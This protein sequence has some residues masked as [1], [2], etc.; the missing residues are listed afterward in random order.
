MKTNTLNVI[1]RKFYILFSLIFIFSAYN[2]SAQTGCE[3]SKDHGQCY[4]T[5]ISSVISNGN[6]SYTIVLIV[7]NSGCPGPGCKKMTHYSVEAD[8]GTYSNISVHT[9]T[10][11][12]TY[13][14]INFGPNIGC[15]FQG[16]RINGTN[17]MGNGQAS[18]FSVTYTLTGGLQDEQAMV[19]TNSSNLI[20]SFSLAD[21]QSVLNCAD[22]NIV[23]YYAAP[24]GGKV[25]DIIG[26]E[27]TS[28]HTTYVT[29]GTYASDDI[30]QIVG[31]SV[32]IDVH[33]KP[34][35]YDSAM[36]ILTSPAYGLA[37]PEGN[38][39][40]NRITGLFPIVNLLMLNSLHTLIKEV[41]PVYTALGNVGIVTSQGDTAMRSYLARNGF[42][43]S[44]QGIKVGV[45]SDSYNT[46]TGDPAH[47]DV[48]RGDLPGPG[49]PDN[50]SPVD[51]VKDYPY[52]SRS[53]EGRAMLQIVHDIAPGAQLAFR[54]GFL[55]VADFAK[56]I[57]ELKQAGCNVIVDDITYI[58][59][60][61]FR[62]GIVSQAV[63][64][65]TSE[66]VAYFSA[67]GNFG[68]RS[69]Q[70]T[71]YPVT[72]PPGITGQ[73][74][75]FAGGTG[76]TDIYQSISLTAGNYTVV[77]QWDDGTAGNQTNSD[78][79]IY[80][81]RPNGTTLFGFNHVNTGGA[82]IEVLPFTVTGDSAQTN[83][84]IIRSAGTGAATLKYVV[85]RG[86]IVI[87]EYANSGGSSTLVGQ[88]NASGAIAVGAVL[89]SNTPEYGVNPP[90][91]ASFSSRGGTPVNGV[92]RNKPDI[93]A[94]N[95]VNTNVNLGGANIDGDQFPN[96]FGT[97]AAAPHAAGVA[98]LL[99]EAKQKYYGTS[100]SPANTRTIL[101]ST[102]LDMYTP[103]YDPASGAGFIQA[104]AALLSLANPSPYITGISYDTTLVPG[105]DTI[106]LTVYGQYLSAQSQIY[107]NGAPL[108]GGTVLSGDT[109]LIGTVLPF[110]ERYPEIQAY[111]PPK[112]GTNGTDGG[113]SN[114]LYFTT[115]ETIV[116]SIDDKSK[117]YGEV[118]PGFTAVY[119]VE[120][121]NGSFPLDSA[122]LTQAETARIL[123]VS[124]ETVATALSNTGLWEIVANSND[125]LN[126]ASQV[127][128][129]D[130]LDISLLER[131][132][133]AFE[134]GLLNIDKLD[135]VIKPNDT[136]FTFGDAIGG[137]SFDYLFN[138]DSNNVVITPQD[139]IAILSALQ[140]S[141]ATAL[142]N[143][144]ALVFA[145]ALVNAGAGATALVN[146]SFMISNATFN[147]HATALVNGTLISPPA[148]YT[149]T[150]LVN[151]VTFSGS[152]ALA[153]ATALVNGD[154]IVN[155]YDA[156]SNL[157]SS[158]PL[159]NATALINAMGGATALVN[160]N[161]INANNNSDAIVILGSGD[162]SI[163]S[164]DSTGSVDLRSV[165]IITG[166][167]VGQHYIIPGSLISNNF[168]I[169]YGLGTL[170]VVPDTAL[171]VIDPASLTQTFTHTARTVGVTTVPA[172][173]PVVVT[174]NGLP[175]G[176]VNAGSYT[177]QAVINDS[178]YVGI[179]TATMVI[180][181]AP[182]TVKA[183]L[184][185]IKAGDPLPTFTS[186][187]TGFLGGDNQSVVT[188][189]T[190]T[191][192]P[193]YNGAPGTYQI[194]P[195]AIAANYLFTPVNGQLYVN[196][197][198]ST[199]KQVCV[200]LQ[201]V[202]VL[203][204]PDSSGFTYLA[205]FT[206]SNT[207]PTD[208]YIPIGADNNL[209]GSGSYNGINQP[210]LFKAGGGTF[211]VPFN[212]VL[213]K[214]TVKSYKKTVKTSSVAQAS[215]SSCH[216]TR[217]AEAEA[218]PV[219]S[220]DQAGSGLKLYPNPTTGIVYIDLNG[221]KVT[222]KDIS[223]FDIYGR[224][225]AT[226][227]VSA[228]DQQLQLDFSGYKSGLYILRIN[229]GIE[230]TSVFRIIKK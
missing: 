60:P 162:I 222:G 152:T 176:P 79:D 41:M 225:C 100:L 59:E 82:P 111:N 62:D 142:V 37:S 55:G 219:I 107:F 138:T 9:L 31:S 203:S 159:T 109:A 39:A 85:F 228:S 120:N 8:P 187:F 191:V 108:S 114:P 28:L 127:P 198:G 2:L 147:S 186:T 5:K 12:F 103:G 25:F 76:G 72:A 74:H 87:N 88:A 123:G 148:F 188:S 106:A 15:P 24:D 135:L 197:Y 17:G 81:S 218:P 44:G 101:Q 174:Y 83:L 161:T 175:N 63:D 221:E 125:P 208:V 102:A 93:T 167:T 223:I 150:A 216:C 75:N 185:V 165:N 78:F 84:M 226:Q 69:Y 95:G 57:H 213:L 3:V 40:G 4:S 183:D 29:T 180:S 119:S 67:A 140:Q 52:S 192:S 204:P 168:N 42:D 227:T 19:K 128:A 56:G 20:V 115:K 116:V 201:C 27:L 195:A 117:K 110:V 182:A 21:F 68:S 36:T 113:L 65:V 171:V 153:P 99:M 139:S 98:A 178:N 190:Y 51:V 224:S 11:N 73:A 89:Y 214:W 166:N 157:T 50:T 136:T 86:N 91:V 121:I 184:K 35:K 1:G 126:P 77:L 49:N 131:Y 229:T 13:S 43:V 151:T 112:E 61:F 64:S 193:T 26:S 104:D 189:L 6:N 155:T 164:G 137:F 33:V 220:G 172:G 132:N 71:F 170:S 230:S 199:A 141:H 53:D 202:E 22:Q 34:G 16:F 45:I 143:G 173:L 212:G 96:F 90:T 205:H 200:S 134:R 58:S 163:L 179:A 48:L 18:S 177:V 38:P 133:F 144:T 105:Q 194:I 92:A 122:G 14:S 94:P 46:I 169:S 209:S 206:Y 7:S 146:K 154:V 30:F 97:S 149:A 129:T 23:P 181:K 54:T 156:D 80:L 10:G 160:A 124:F 211:N 130:S 66:G 32:V 47:D 210:K 217:S 207:N 196:P 118:L 158:T 70:S 215:S 145:T